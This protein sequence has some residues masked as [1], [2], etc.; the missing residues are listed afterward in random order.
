[1]AAL[2]VDMAAKREPYKQRSAYILKNHSKLEAW[3]KV[4]QS[5]WNPMRNGL[6]RT[7]MW[8][9][10]GFIVAVGWAFYFTNADRAE[11]IGPIIYTLSRLTVP[12]VA[13]A[14][15]S[16]FPIGVRTTVVANAATYALIGLI[17]GTIRRYSRPHQISN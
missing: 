12:L 14:S 4:W 9:T 7:V 1:V 16:D 10:V 8:A 2:L 6:A 11:P 5:S 3:P 13:I 17:L 15:Y